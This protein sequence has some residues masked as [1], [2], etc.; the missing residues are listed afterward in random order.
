ML[1]DV[2]H[3]LVDL[4]ADVRGLWQAQQEI[5]SG[6]WHQVENAVSVIGCRVVNA[7][8][9]PRAVPVPTFRPGLFQLGALIGEAHFGEAQEDQA[10]NGCRVFLRFEAGIGPELV[11]GVPEAPF[12]RG[13]IGVFFR[14]GDPD[15]SLPWRVLQSTPLAISNSVRR[16]WTGPIHEE[17]GTASSPV[18]LLKI[19]RAGDE[20]VPAPISFPS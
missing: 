19:Q 17:V 2:A 15:H 16:S 7:A 8:A 18:R 20:A 12:Q 4:R 10:K 9:A 1:L 5:E 3:G 11:G 14:R 13:V 6:G